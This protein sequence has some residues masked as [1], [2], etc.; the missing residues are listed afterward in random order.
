[1][2]NGLSRRLAAVAAAVRGRYQALCQGPCRY[3]LLVFLPSATAVLLVSAWQAAEA[4][5]QALRELGLEQDHG[6]E[7]AERAFTSTLN[8]SM[9]GLQALEQRP[10]L[11]QVLSDPSAA[12]RA[13]LGQTAIVMAES[14][15]LYDQ[16]RWL[17]EDGQERVRV[18]WQ[19]GRAQ[20]VPD[21]LLQNKN[22]RY[23]VRDARQLPIGS[24]YISPLDLNIENGRLETPFKPMLRLVRPLREEASGQRRGFLVLNVLAEPMLDAFSKAAQSRAMHGLVVNGQLVNDQGY[25]LRSA[26]PKSDWGF[27]TGKPALL[28]SR[29]PDAWRW[30]RRDRNGQRRL[31]SGLWTWRTVQP[32]SA[33]MLTSDG[34][35]GAVQ[36]FSAQPRWIAVSQVT[37]DQLRALEWRVTA[38]FAG[39]TALLLVAVAGL[40]RWMGRRLVRGRQAAARLELVAQNAADVIFAADADGSLNWLSASAQELLGLETQTLLGRTIAELVVEADRPAAEQAQARAAAGDA[41]QLEA[42]F[43]A[44][45][46]REPWLE[47]SI[48]AVNGT[49]GHRSLVGSW[50]TIDAQRQAEQGRRDADRRMAAVM[51]IAPVGMAVASPEGRL[52]EVNPAFCSMLHRDRQELLASSWQEITYPADLE[53]DQALVQQIIDGEI[54]T[55]RLRKRYFTPDGTIVWTDLSV[56]GLRSVDGRVEGFIAQVMDIT[57]SVESERKLAKARDRYRLLAENASDVVLQADH[58]HQLQWLSPSAVDLFGASREVIKDSFFTDWLH[59]QDREAFEQ[60][61]RRQEV[62]S[63]SLRP[64]QGALLRL[65]SWDNRYR[66]VS[67]RLTLLRDR[68][69]SIYGEV[70]ALRD[71][72]EETSARQQLDRQQTFLRATLNSLLDPHI[73]LDPLRDDN[74]WIIDFL[75]AGGNSASYIYLGVEPSRLVGRRLTS[76]FPGVAE[77]GLLDRYRH[78]M[79][80]GEPLVLNDFLYTNQEVLG[81]DIVTDVRAVRAAESLSLTWRDVGD[82]YRKTQELA[83]SEER[84]RLLAENATD[85][86]VHIKDNRITWISTNAHTILGAAAEQWTGKGV[87]ELL[88]PEDLSRYF[89]ALAAIEKGE[90][91]SQRVR[92]RSATGDYHWFSVYAKTFRN[93]SG[94]PDGISASLRNIDAEVAAAQEL[95]YRASH[96]LLTG[97]LNRSEAIHRLEALLDHPDPRAGKTGVLF[98]DVDKF[99]QVNDSHGHAAGDA[100]LITLATRI[101]SCLRQDDLAVRMG[102]DELLVVLRGLDDLQQA[103]VIAEKLRQA[104][105]QPI[106]CDGCSVQVSLSIGVAIAAA[107]ETVD[108]LIAR[109]DGAMY[110][111]KQGGRNQVIAIDSPQ[112]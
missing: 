88:H 18:N 71:V 20:L 5:R 62:Q 74:G 50:R 6:L 72:D 109:A 10:E 112:P 38:P 89:D 9:Q 99:K 57:A 12:N 30:I 78:V 108:G 25:G 2:Q 16:I 81:R 75:F 69:H 91:V 19:G 70:L 27:Q 35:G 40:S 90:L 95:D 63:R 41:V 33:S 1:M 64:E 66:W 3:S 42:R 34:K 22:D 11:Q 61:R 15:R 17:N 32:F 86:I 29:Y 26:D 79:E 94:Q 82:R 43:Q 14:L 39:G 98:I 21:A 93:A 51:E 104:G 73:T 103:V 7:M 96:D 84:Y 59:P 37:P 65:R 60:L 101:Q 8:F 31:A 44:A 45:G 4:R 68:G 80:T 55:Y 102:G 47:V 67:L 85:L 83:A 28:P 56:A 24:T 107:A 100:V 77:Q 49:D 87:Q 46:G 97:L 13:A 58:K 52:V 23:Y 92:I 110:T 76:I 53:T 48:R 111:A 36:P 106:D 105:S 54:D